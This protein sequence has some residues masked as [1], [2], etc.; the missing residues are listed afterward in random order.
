[1]E[2]LMISGV[3]RRGHDGESGAVAERGMAVVSRDGSEVG[4]V[5]AVWVTDRS[6]P[7]AILLSRLPALMEYRLVPVELVV[8]VDDQRVILDLAPEEIDGLE[9]WSGS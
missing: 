1:M 6:I 3:M 9:I 2:R 8:G 5:A 7:R 4:R